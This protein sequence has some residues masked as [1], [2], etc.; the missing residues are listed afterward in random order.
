MVFSSNTSSTP[1]K[2]PNTVS[3]AVALKTRIADVIKK[4]AI[5][6]S[7]VRTIA[8]FALDEIIEFCITLMPSSGAI[9]LI[10]KAQSE[11]K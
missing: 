8:K 7:Q 1:A 11:I 5:E 2:I 4:K 6:P 3:L 9:A 10:I